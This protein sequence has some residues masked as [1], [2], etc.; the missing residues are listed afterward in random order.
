MENI[1]RVFHCDKI[2]IPNEKD[3]SDHAGHTL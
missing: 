2:P 3:I 1:F